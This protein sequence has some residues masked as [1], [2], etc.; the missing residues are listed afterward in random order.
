MHMMKM[1]WHAY[2]TQ[3]RCIHVYIYSIYIYIP[4]AY[5]GID[6]FIED[7][8]DAWPVDLHHPCPGLLADEA[9]P[10]HG[11]VASAD[12]IYIYIRVYIYIYIHARRCIYTLR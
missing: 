6:T 7:V 1:F 11:F 12:Y 9:S 4:M 10:M 2:I 5:I 3:Q 8:H